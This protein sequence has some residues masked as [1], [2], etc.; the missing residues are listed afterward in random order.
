VNVK[1]DYELVLISRFSSYL[2]LV[3]TTGLSLL[4]DRIQI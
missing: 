4:A 2:P 3:M 1:A